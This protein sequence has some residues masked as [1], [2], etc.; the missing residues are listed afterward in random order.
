MTAPTLVFPNYAL[1]RD[2]PAV[3]PP[4]DRRN[5]HRP[6]I[7][8]QGTLSTNGGH[9]DLREIFAAIRSEGFPMD[10]YPSRPVFGY[11]AMHPTLSPARLL[12]ELPQYD[13]GWAGFNSTLNGDHLDTCLPN[14]AYEY[15]GCGLPVLTLTH[16]ALKR[17]VEGEQLGLSL[18]TLDD[19][20][21]QLADADVVELRRRAAER[22]LDLTFEAN[23]HRLAELYERVAA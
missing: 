1:R 18:A 2:L 21:L 14:K 22:R 7:V 6:R 4:F 10:V 17:L 9:Y 13:F 19:L 5:G 8:Y 16:R 20:E 15:I 11:G 23:V 3:L 12:R